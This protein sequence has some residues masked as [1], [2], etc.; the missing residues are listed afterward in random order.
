M[1][2]TRGFIGY[3]WPYL[4]YVFKKNQSAK[5][6][7]YYEHICIGNIEASCFLSHI[8]HIMGLLRG[9]GQ[10]RENKHQ[11]Q[12]AKYIFHILLKVILLLT[13]PV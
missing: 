12:N 8:S 4:P 5:I 10:Q 2:H 13:D 11:E 9:S 1:N 7:K 3:M 6:V